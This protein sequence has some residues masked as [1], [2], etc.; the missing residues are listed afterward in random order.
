MTTDHLPHFVHFLQDEDSYPHPVPGLRLLQTHISYVFLAGDYVYKFKKPVNFGFLDFST[1]EKRK[2]YCEQELRLN[3]RLCPDI[4]LETV[5]INEEQNKLTLNGKGRAMEYGV[6]MAR[7][8]EEGMMANLI[9]AGTLTS[10]HID[11]IV[12][13]LVPFYVKA[14]KNNRINEFGRAEAVAVNVLENFEQ[15]RPYMTIFRDM[16]VKY[17]PTVLS[18]ISAS[19]KT[20][21]VIAMA[22]SIRQIS[23]LTGKG[24]IFSTASN[25]TSDFAT[26]I[27]Q[28]TSPF[29][30]WILMPMTLMSCPTTLS[31]ALLNQA[32]TG[33]CEKCSVFINATVQ[34]YV[35][36]S[37][38]LPP[39]SRKLTRQPED[40]PRKMRPVTF[41]WPSNTR[42]NV[43]QE[44]THLCLFRDDCFG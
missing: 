40:S 4:Y 31:T 8:P 23:V 25:S 27:S 28:A 26:L 20:A 38:S 42:N 33:I 14:E 39:T 5:S 24:C 16:P 21:S 3:R 44:T 35:A 22:I 32:G 18:L 9:A 37:A 1:L 11:T 36:R 19:V 30:P 29:W 6:K 41:Y 12:A 43:G 34:P 17:L 15:A 7:M 13:T 10:R 2:F